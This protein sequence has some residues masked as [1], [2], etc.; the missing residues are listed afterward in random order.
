MSSLYPGNMNPCTNK[1][2]PDPADTSTMINAHDELPRITSYQTLESIASSGDFYNKPTA[3]DV[4][5]IFAAIAADITK[6][7][8]RLVDDSY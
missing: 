5:Q 6:G 7:T 2:M 1:L 4:T 8:S 3:G